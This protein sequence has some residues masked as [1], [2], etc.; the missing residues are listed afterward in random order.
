[1]PFVIITGT[2]HS[3]VAPEL[4]Q[5]KLIAS[6]R[7][8]TSKLPMAYDL[9]QFMEKH[10]KI[11]RPEKGTNIGAFLAEANADK[12]TINGQV[13]DMM[14][15]EMKEASGNLDKAYKGLAQRLTLILTH[16]REHILEYESQMRALGFYWPLSSLQAEV[17]GVQSES[18]LYGRMMIN[19]S[20]ATVYKETSPPRNYIIPGGASTITEQFDAR[21][22]KAHAIRESRN[23]DAFLSF[24]K[25]YYPN[26]IDLAEIKRQDLALQLKAINKRELSA[27]DSKKLSAAIIICESPEK[28][29]K[30]LQWY[31][32]RS[33]SRA[34]IFVP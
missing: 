11:Q 27:D 3:Q 18:E 30:L 25:L 16:E 22:S 20:L 15:L 21:I 34:M 26:A 24:C 10:V 31:Q 32:N 29:N 2:H 6:L 7:E 8:L 17:S 13:L 12:I 19:S 33:I 14:L 9:V 5:T 28:F 1:M 23:A 4:D